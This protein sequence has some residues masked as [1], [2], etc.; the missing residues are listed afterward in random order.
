MMV[1][2]VDTVKI[3]TGQP[4]PV[5]V[6]VGVVVGEL[7]GELVGAGV[8]DGLELGEG[9]TDGLGEG[10]GFPFPLCP[11]GFTSTVQVTCTV[12]VYVADPSVAKTRSPYD[13]SSRGRYA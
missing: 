13:P 8:G 7:V 3:L 4:D 9:S 5:G 2:G 12:A 10:D 1:E 11:C 6:P